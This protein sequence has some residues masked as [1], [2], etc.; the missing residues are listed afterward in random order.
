MRNLEREIANLARKVVKEIL[1]DE[2][3]VDPRHAAR[4]SR[5]SAACRKFRY[6][7]AELEDLVGVVTGLAWTEVGG[8]LLTD[9][10]RDDARQGQDDGH[11]QPAAT[12]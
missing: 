9:R 8:E 3:E 4:I 12:S 7:E 6:G 5:T 2:E 10:R 11:R 1:I